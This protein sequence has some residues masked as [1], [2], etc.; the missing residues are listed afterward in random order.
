MS[1]LATL[2]L[3]TVLAASSLIIISSAFAQSIT[4]PSIPEFT[5]EYV[6]NSYD[7]APT[8]TTDPYTNNKVIQTYGDHVDNRTVVIT[9]KNEPFTPFTDS[10]GNTINM[11]YNVCYKGSFGQYWTRVYGVERM[12]SNYDIPDNKYGYKIQ[13]YGSQ[14]TVV[15]IKSPPSQGQMDIQVEALQGYTNRTGE[16]HIIFD[17][18]WYTFYGEESGWSD[19]QTLTV[20]YGLEQVILIGAAISAVVID[21]CLVLVYFIKRKQPKVHAL[22]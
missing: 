6:D 16:G 11:F 12:V 21:A 8:Y 19:I 15:L 14:N 9:I 17:V 2:L 18:V 7:I 10:D 3:I 1:K 20:G 4:K 22:V 5:A 13:D